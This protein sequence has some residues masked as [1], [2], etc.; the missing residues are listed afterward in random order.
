MKFSKI[1][2]Y[3]SNRESKFY[4]WVSK[5]E[6]EKILRLDESHIHQVEFNSS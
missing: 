1:K 2:F 5:K 6:R 4:T 3:F